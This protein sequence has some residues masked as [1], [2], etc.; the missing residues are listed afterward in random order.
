MRL[1]Q[2]MMYALALSISRNPAGYTG[3]QIKGTA[4]VIEHG[5]VYDK[6]ARQAAGEGQ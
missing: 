4:T 3:Y 1:G 5:P 6:L 2:R